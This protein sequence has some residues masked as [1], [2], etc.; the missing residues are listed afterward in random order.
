MSLV[1]ISYYF[2]KKYHNQNIQIGVVNTVEKIALT[3]EKKGYH[4]Y[5]QLE[6]KV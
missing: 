5:F 3:S 1:Q 6:I 2:N 4:A